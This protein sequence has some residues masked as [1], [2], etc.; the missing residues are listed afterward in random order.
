MDNV[1]RLNEAVQYIEQHLT[2]K[3]D[4]GNLAKIAL[5][6]KYSLGKIF[7]FL[8]G[9][10]LSEYIRKRR[11]SQADIALQT[12]AP[13]IIDL[14]VQYGYDSLEAFARAFKKMH[15]INPSEVKPNTFL[16]TFN[17][18]RFDNSASTAELDIKIET[19]PGLTLYGLRTTIPIGQIEHNAPLFWKDL[20]KS[21]LC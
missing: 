9:F 12:G 3:I 2:Q 18:I 8:S 15:G 14:A 16:K 20:K 1:N 11:L 17:V 10:S 6:D 21:A 19:K 7:C 13:R 4:Y 5:V